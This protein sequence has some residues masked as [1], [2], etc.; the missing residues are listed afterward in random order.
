MAIFNL[1]MTSVD[2]FCGPAMPGTVLIDDIHLEAPW[3]APTALKP[4]TFGLI[5]GERTRS[6]IEWDASKLT[7]RR[8]DGKDP[9]VLW[10]KKL[11]DATIFPK[12]IEFRDKRGKVDKFKFP[13]SS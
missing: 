1:D 12:H 10:E 9:A 7:M 4:S 6:R 8:L 5:C 11:E 2:A 3:W 13:W